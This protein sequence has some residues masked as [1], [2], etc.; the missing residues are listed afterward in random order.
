[1]RNGLQ[2]QL[3]LLQYTVGDTSVRNGSFDFNVSVQNATDAFNVAVTS[4]PDFILAKDRV[5]LAKADLAVT[6][7]TDRPSLSVGANAGMKNGYVPNVNDLRFNYA[8]GVNLKIPI[9]NAKTKKQLAVAESQVKQNQ[10]AQETLSNEYQKNIQQ[11]LTDIQSNTEKIKNMKPQ[12]ETTISAQQIAASRYLNG[13]GLNT[14]I[15]DAAVNV[16]RARLT[17]L[18]YEYQLCLA[19]VEY[20]RLTGVKY[21]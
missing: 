1:L 17:E 12:I 13:I 14:E 19:K 11:A 18:Q 7:L 15:T 2:R 4:V 21:W 9:Y 5:E 3:T 20:A 8:A 6:R 10:L 16:Q